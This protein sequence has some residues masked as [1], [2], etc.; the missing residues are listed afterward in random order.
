M[1]LYRDFN[2]TQCRENLRG[3]L[4]WRNY[5]G[6]LYSKQG[7]QDNIKYSQTSVHERLGSW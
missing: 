3:L 7:A 5:V 4:L 6:V 2:T 1:S